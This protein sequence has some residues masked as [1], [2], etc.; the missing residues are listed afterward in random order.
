MTNI[1]YLSINSNQSIFT[2]SYN[3]KGKVLTQKDIRNACNQIHV[4][5]STI[6]ITL[7]DKP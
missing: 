7:V 1:N 4:M 5:K 3:A 6:L 2:I